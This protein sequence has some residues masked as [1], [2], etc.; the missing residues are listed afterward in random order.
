[1]TAPPLTPARRDRGLPGAPPPSPRRRRVV[2]WA[3]IA[4]I[5]LVLGGAAAVIASS[6]QWTAR[7]ALDPGSAGPRGTRALAQVLAQHGVQVQVVRD[8]A[9]ASAALAGGDAT[10]VMADSPYLSDGAFAALADA[11]ADVV[12]IDPRSRGVAALFP[13]AE[14]A[15]F[16]GTDPVAPGCELPDAVRAGAIVPGALYVGGEATGCYRD[17]PGA[18]LLVGDR[19]GGR[20]AAIDATELFTNEHLAENGNAALALN[21]MG[22]H[23]RLVWYV[24]S[25]DDSDLADAQPD[26]AEL[27]PAWVTPALT[28]LACAGLAAACWRGRRFGPLVAENLPVTVRAG[29]TT[30]G[31]ARLYAASRDAGHAADQLRI[32]ALGRLARDLGLG[33]AA[34]AGEIADAAAARVGGDRARVR[35]ILWGDVPRTDRDLVA[36]ADRLRDLETAVRAAV[37][38]AGGAGAR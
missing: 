12:V 28:L 8:R 27:T 30:A 4:L 7:D 38:P 18:A 24:A 20:V 9:A 21:L 13:G 6:M 2:G 23:P 32:A 3:A 15:G 33:P 10:L 5:A 35:A 37:R 14:T 11:A 25:I 26:I 1:M 19:G 36:L 22:R 17:G 31:R 34:S 16:G 29:E